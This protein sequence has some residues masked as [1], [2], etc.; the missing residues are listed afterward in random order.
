M[1]ELVVID[2]RKERERIKAL[3]SH[4]LHEAMHAERPADVEYDDNVAWCVLF[5]RA[6]GDIETRWLRNLL[7]MAGFGEGEVEEAEHLWREEGEEGEEGE[8]VEGDAVVV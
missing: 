5:L 1:V 3:R 6:H 8:E 7:L 2:P 4:A